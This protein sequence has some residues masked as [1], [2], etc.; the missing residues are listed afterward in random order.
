MYPLPNT[1]HELTGYDP[2]TTRHPLSQVSRDQSLPFEIDAKAVFQS[3]LENEEIPLSER[4]KYLVPGS[5]SPAWL[6][7]LTGKKRRRKRKTKSYLESHDKGYRFPDALWKRELNEE[8]SGK[9]GKEYV[10]KVRLLEAL[11]WLRR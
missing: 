1:P 10:D 9:L 3:F 7:H 11:E 2:Y 4:M 8:A 5:L 6:S